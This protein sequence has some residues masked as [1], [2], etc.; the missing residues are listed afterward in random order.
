MKMLVEFEYDDKKMGVGWF[1]IHYLESCLYSKE[2]I[3][4]EL[5]KAK[6]IKISDKGGK[7]MDILEKR[8]DEDYDEYYLR[9]KEEEQC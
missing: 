9:K 6:E 7:Q 5:L 8:Q 2:H 1:D 4:K 3:K